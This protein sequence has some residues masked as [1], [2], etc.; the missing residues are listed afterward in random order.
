MRDLQHSNRINPP[1]YF[2]E[3]IEKLAATGGSKQGIAKHFGVS[4]RVLQGW[5]DENEDFAEAYK[6]GRDQERQKLHNVLVREAEKGNITAA[7]ALLKSR[8]GYRDN[9]TSDQANKIAITFN[10]PGAMNAAEYQSR[11]KTIDA[12]VRPAKEDADG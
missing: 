9:E 8:H 11:G 1:A 4:L 3:D 10:L 6:Q 2:R 5:M 12:V 7:M